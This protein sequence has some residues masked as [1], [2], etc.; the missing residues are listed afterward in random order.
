MAVTPKGIYYPSTP[1]AQADLLTDLEDM[2][3]SIDTALDNVVIPV[4]SALSPTSENP[5]QNKVITANIEDLEAYSYYRGILQ[6][7][8]TKEKK[9]ELNIY[10]AEKGIYVKPY[11]SNKLKKNFDSP[12]YYDYNAASIIRNGKEAKEYIKY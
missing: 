9:A 1:S 12:Y 11:F 3:E 4:D 5:V 10:L 6:H 2:A 7:L 8:G